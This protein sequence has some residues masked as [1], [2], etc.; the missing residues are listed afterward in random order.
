VNFIAGELAK[1]CNSSCARGVTVL[2]RVIGRFMWDRFHYWSFPILGALGIVGA[3]AK[4]IWR[5][6]LWP[7]ITRR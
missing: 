1:G 5:R 7:W 2:G 6:L 4:A 3:F